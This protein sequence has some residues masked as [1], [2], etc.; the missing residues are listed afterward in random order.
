MGNLE[1]TRFV[2]RY[3]AFTATKLS[4]AAGALAVALAAS[5]C[6]SANTATSPSANETAPA[7]AV[8]TTSSA[9][10][11][12]QQDLITARA[13]W[14]QAKPPTYVVIATVGNDFAAP[15]ECRWRVNGAEVDLIYG[16]NTRRCEGQEI[17]TPEDAFGSI[18]A[19][20]ASPAKLEVQVTY[21]AQGVP[22]SAAIVIP[23][24]ADGNRGWTMTVQSA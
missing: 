10:L 3:V 15:N 12:E 6:S 20:L 5:A 14:A 8:P 9:L 24:T 7:T 1:T 16:L 22:I 18:E 17:R 11:A 23:N 2:K 4:L 21:N 13:R 19:A